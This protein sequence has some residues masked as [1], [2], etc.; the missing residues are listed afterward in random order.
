MEEQATYLSVI[1]PVY[2]EQENL[3]SLHDSLTSVLRELSLSYEV[4]YVD[5]GSTDSSFELLCHLAEGDPQL[6]VVR[7][8]RNFGQAAALAAGIA[9][10]RG[11]VL[12]CLDADHQNDPRDI[13]RLLAK[14]EEGY[15][16]VSGWRRRRCD[17]GLTRRLPSLVAN[18]LIAR[19]TGVPL[20]DFGCTLKVYRRTLF[21]QIRLYGEMHRFIPVYAAMAGAAITEMEVAHHPRRAG[22]SKYGLD[23]TARVL[24][25]LL[26]LRFQIHFATRPHHAAGIG[27]LLAFVLGLFCLLLGLLHGPR[28][29]PA[30]RAA[31]SL[32]SMAG[33][34]FG[35]AWISLKL[36]WL[37]ELQMRTYYESQ[38]RTPYVVRSVIPDPA[39]GA[40]HPGK[41][42]LKVAREAGYG[43]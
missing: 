11:R 22:R 7:L 8:S 31:A 6:L 5:D 4:I 28:E 24:F 26:L 25:D 21:E 43:G 16:L 36:G 41:R 37:A 13:P 42:L 35:I 10:S 17:A 33:C 40:D 15:D 34:C 23:R 9:H 14:L 2:N 1:I 12:A 3:V 19:A 27:G 20:H 30:E 38:G 32:L 39:R 18:A 29:Q